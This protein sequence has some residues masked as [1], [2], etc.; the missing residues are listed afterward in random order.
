MRLSVTSWSFPQLTLTEVAGLARTLGIGA[1]DVGYFYRSALSRDAILQDPEGEARR[2]HATLGG[3]RPANLYHLFGRT[4]AERN[5][6]Q[7]GTLKANLHDL[8][9][10]LLFAEAADIP[11]VFI[12]PGIVNP[13]QSRRDA[14]QIATEALQAM[15]ELPGARQRL[16]LE[17]HVHSWLESPDLVHRLIETTGMRIVLDPAH[18]LCLG[19]PQAEIDNLAPHAAHVHLRQAR[20]GALQAKFAE[21]TI[22]FPALFGTL[23]EAGYDG[24]LALEAVHQDYMGTLHEDVLTETVRM[25]DAF[26][27]WSAQDG[28]GAEGA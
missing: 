1:V 20:P 12:L 23:R 10:V 21:G 18:F 13:G 25:R 6:A 19:Y 8:H 7:P 27:S 16:C 24:Y 9:S 28:A 4:L 5:L 11:T 26:R 22:N 17:P 3:I 2:L 15:L 14:A